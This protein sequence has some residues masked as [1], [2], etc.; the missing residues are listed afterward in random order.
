MKKMTKRLG[1]GLVSLMGFGV[2]NTVT[3]VSAEIVGEADTKSDVK[4]VAP[5]PDEEGV[6]IKP[7]TPDD[8]IKPEGGGQTKGALRISHVPDIHFGTQKISSDIETVYTSI[9]ERYQELSADGETL[10]PEVYSIPHFA[11]VVDERGQTKGA[12]WQLLVK[13]TTFKSSNSEVPELT[14]TYISMK[15]QQIFNT[16]HEQSELDKRVIGFDCKT[17]IKLSSESVEI[18]A[19]K[20]GQHTSCTKTSSVFNDSYT[21]ETDYHVD[22]DYEKDSRNTGIRLHTFAKDIK[23]KDEVYASTLT[24]TLN[25]AL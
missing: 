3:N 20:A 13:A 22:N 21:S 24:W 8:K 15:E 10:D 25:D 18:L 9:N 2:I 23:M 12:E 7:D 5:G 19:V 11:Q 1:V 16:V 14:G 17:G 4:F 6:I